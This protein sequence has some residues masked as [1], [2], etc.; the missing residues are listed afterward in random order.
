MYTNVTTM[1]ERLRAMR[2]QPWALTRDLARASRYLPQL[3][4]HGAWAGRGSD[5]ED[6]ND[7]DQSLGAGLSLSLGKAVGCLLCYLSLDETS[8]EFYPTHGTVEVL[9]QLAAM[10]ASHSLDNA[11]RR[12]ARLVLV[13]GAAADGKLENPWPL[14]SSR[15]L[16]RTSW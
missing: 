15:R 14:R 16:R 12:P 5:N 1:A 6:S 9:A 4:V 11:V 3:A 8:A 13:Q 2:G 10:V 7:D